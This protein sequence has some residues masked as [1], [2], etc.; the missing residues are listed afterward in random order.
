[1]CY[2]YLI[3]LII[4]TIYCPFWGFC[5]AL[6]YSTYHNTADLKSDSE[7]GSAESHSML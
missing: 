6:C 3:Y 1:M 5:A 2:G 7:C 4:V